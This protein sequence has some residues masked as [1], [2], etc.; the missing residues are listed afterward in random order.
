[1]RANREK[2]DVLLLLDQVVGLLVF[3]VLE[4]VLVEVL[5][6]LLVAEVDTE[7]FEGVH[8]EV[9]EAEDVLRSGANSF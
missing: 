3:N 2:E 4:D 1:M 6:Q 8:L 7:L 5:L 9:L